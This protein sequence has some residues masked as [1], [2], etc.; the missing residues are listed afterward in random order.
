MGI[1][2]HGEFLFYWITCFSYFCLYCFSS[3]ANLNTPNNVYLRTQ[4]R[5][6]RRICE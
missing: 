6:I 1:N 4:K 3:F 2:T 5:E